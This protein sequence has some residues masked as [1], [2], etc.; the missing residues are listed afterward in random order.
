MR[1]I[2]TKLENW[3]NIKLNIKQRV[4]AEYA[5]AIV[6]QKSIANIAPPVCIIVLYS[7][8]TFGI[9]EQMHKLLVRCLDC[10]DHRKTLK[11]NI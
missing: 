11:P 10:Y 2:K 6:C 7:Q 5:L 8:Q 9:R 3:K 1:Y 4:Q